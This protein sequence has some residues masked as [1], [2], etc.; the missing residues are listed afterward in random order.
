MFQRKFDLSSSSCDISQRRLTAM[1]LQRQETLK[2]ILQNK[3]FET[4]H[5]TN[6]FLFSLLKVCSAAFLALMPNLILLNLTRD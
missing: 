6:L 5:Y 4:K 3:D 2:I 1:N